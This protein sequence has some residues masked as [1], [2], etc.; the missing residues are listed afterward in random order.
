MEITRE[1]LMAYTDA[2]TKTAAAL[3]KIADRLID[4][5]VSQK[6][7]HEKFCTNMLEIIKTNHSLLINI[8][9]KTD[10]ITLLKWLWFSIGALVA[11]SWILFK[12]VAAIHGSGG[13]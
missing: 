10:D 2:A 7:C 8:D 6:D 5:S 3:E 1:E 11:I 4:I 13:A 9:K 12:I